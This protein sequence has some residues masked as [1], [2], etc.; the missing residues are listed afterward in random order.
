MT[1]DLDGAKKL[2]E[3]SAEQCSRVGIREGV[4]EAQEALR[5]VEKMKKVG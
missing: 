3:K 2:F 4:V 1:S 5:R